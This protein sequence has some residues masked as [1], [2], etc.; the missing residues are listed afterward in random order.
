MGS[1]L[2]IFVPEE[3]KPT[4]SYSSLSSEHFQLSLWAVSCI[5]SS[6]DT[7]VSSHPCCEHISSSRSVKRK[8]EGFSLGSTPNGSGSQTRRPP[9]SS[10]PHHELTASTRPHQLPLFRAQIHF[11]DFFS[12][13]VDFLHLASRCSPSFSLCKFPEPPSSAC[14]TNAG[15]SSR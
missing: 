14:E 11:V 4:L 13:K 3:A 15:R 1:S 6:N 12:P 8:A 10:R 2:K 7:S 9:A 5:A